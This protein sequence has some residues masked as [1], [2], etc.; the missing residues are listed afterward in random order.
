MNIKAKTALII[1]ITLALGIVI[2][3]MLNRALLQRR[4]NRAFSWRSPDFM[5][6]NFE[7]IIEP[8]QKQRKLIRQILNKH[9]E[10]M[11]ELRENSRKDMQEEFESL[12]KELDLILTPEQK[13]RLMRRLPDPLRRFRRFQKGPPFKPPPKKKPPKDKRR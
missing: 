13:N 9:A 4:I 1:I 3:A 2:G 6:T 10:R 5:I 7:N 8:G 12:Q 11:M